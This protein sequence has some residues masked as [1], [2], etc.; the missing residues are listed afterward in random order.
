MNTSKYLNASRNIYR[1]YDDDV[2]FELDQPTSRHAVSSTLDAKADAQDDTT[3]G[4]NA[5]LFLID[6]LNKEFV[7]LGFESFLSQSF[8]AYFAGS[9]SR[10]ESMRLFDVAAGSD[11]L[12]GLIDSGLVVRNTLPLIERYKRNLKPYEAEK[13]K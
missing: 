4:R 12:A 8:H 3:S 6:Y 11:A 10:G 7:S 1:E 2:G 13:E 5:D 9:P